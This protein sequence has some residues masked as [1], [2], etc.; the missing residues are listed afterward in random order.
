MPTAPKV[1]IEQHKKRLEDLKKAK[2]DIEAQ[3][4]QI[5][6][7][8]KSSE[9]TDTLPMWEALTDLKIKTDKAL[10]KIDP[11]LSMRN[12]ATMEEYYLY[13]HPTDKK[14]RTRDAEAKW[15]KDTIA[16]KNNKITLAR[17]EEAAAKQRPETW[18]VVRKHLKL[19]VVKKRQKRTPKDNDSA[20][21]ETGGLEKESVKKPTTNKPKTSN[22]T[23]YEEHK[24]ESKRLKGL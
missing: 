20:V 1:T 10:K 24:T 5:L 21:L 6:L 11:R 8:M 18:K 2:K 9:I 15:V 13:S 23:Q 7:D 17:M 14:K 22:K 16:N 12:L 4:K 19:D 3:E